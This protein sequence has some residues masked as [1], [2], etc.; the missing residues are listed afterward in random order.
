MKKSIFILVFAFCATLMSAQISRTTTTTTTQDTDDETFV[1]KGRVM[2]ETGYNLFGG[3][4]F[5]GGTGF[6]LLT[7]G[8]ST[9]SSLGFSGGYFVSE[10]FALKFGYSNLSG[11]FLSLSGYQLGGKYYAGKVPLDFTAGILTGDGQT[12]FIGNI[13]GGYAIEL[14]N[15]IMLEPSLG[16]V[17]TEYEANI[18]FKVNFA[19]FL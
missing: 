1:R 3:L 14:A 17:L 16:L 7:D 11:D 12:D 9:I 13:S 4:P 5:G 15:N 2:V 18:A 10:N 8:E 19:M 6:T